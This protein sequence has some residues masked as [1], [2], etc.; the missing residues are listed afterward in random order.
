MARLDRASGGN[1]MERAM[2]GSSRAMTFVNVSGRGRVG[3]RPGAW[4]SDGM[5]RTRPSRAVSR[6]GA[7][8][9][10]IDR[11]AMAR[12]TSAA[13]ERIHQRE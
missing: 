5:K 10:D 12:G 2:A 9:I 7:W 11:P 4:A 13:V 6:K 8:V 3:R 1:T